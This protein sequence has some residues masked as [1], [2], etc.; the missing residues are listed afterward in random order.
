MT[1]TVLKSQEFS[2][3]TY[4]NATQYID[5]YKQ[6]QRRHT[7]RGVAVRVRKQQVSNVSLG[8]T[9]CIYVPRVTWLGDCYVLCKLPAGNW[10]KEVGGC[11]IKSFRIF[12]GGELI[13]D[14]NNYQTWVHYAKSNMDDEKR[15]KFESFLGGAATAGGAAAKVCCLPLPCFWSSFCRDNMQMSEPLCA[16]KLAPNGLKFELELNNGAFCSSDG[17]AANLVDSFELVFQQKMAED[18]LR[19]RH[20]KAPFQY[21]ARDYRTLSSKAMAAAADTEIDA[22]ALSGQVR[23]LHLHVLPSASKAAKD[24]FAEAPLSKLICRLDGEDYKRLETQQEV[25]AEDFLNGHRDANRVDFTVAPKLNAVAGHLNTQRIRKLD[26]VLQTSLAA[27]CNILAVF[28]RKFFVD[29]SGVL[30]R[31]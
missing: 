28:D 21:Q 31:T 8:S 24:Y 26:L 17:A 16:G 5:I 13:Q 25:E 10:A 23:S 19:Q 20:L 15:A 22:S 7:L 9:T 14:I 12:S 18:D 4:N 6:G 3:A 30:R 2:A 29:G 11:V 1:D 27:E